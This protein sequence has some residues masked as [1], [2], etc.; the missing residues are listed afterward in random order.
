[1]KISMQIILCMLV[2]WLQMHPYIKGNLRDTWA[3]A[4]SLLVL[5]VLPSYLKGLAHA[6]RYTH[7]YLACI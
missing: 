3:R 2:A 1:M 6:V 4:F 5:Q 7:V